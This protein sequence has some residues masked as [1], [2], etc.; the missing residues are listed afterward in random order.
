MIYYRYPTKAEIL[1]NSPV[2]LNA[3]QVK[4]KVLLGHGFE[5]CEVFD[6]GGGGV[7]VIIKPLSCDR[8]RG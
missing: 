2:D 3:L 4:P 5:M 6:R 1:T 8:D 7:R